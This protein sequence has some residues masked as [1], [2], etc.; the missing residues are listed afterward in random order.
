MYFIFFAVSGEKSLLR[1]YRGYLITASVGVRGGVSRLT[2]SSTPETR[3][4]MVYDIQNQLVGMF[5][6]IHVHVH[7]KVHFVE[8]VKP[9]QAL[10]WDIKRSKYSHAGRL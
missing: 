5:T 6:S 1:W 4:L 2:S 10:Q 9:C 8:L 3:T 7:V